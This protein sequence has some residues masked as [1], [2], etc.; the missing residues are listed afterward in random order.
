MKVREYLIDC[1]VSDPGSF[2]QIAHGVRDR[3]DISVFQ[4]KKGGVIALGDLDP[5][6]APSYSDRDT[7]DYWADELRSSSSLD[8][9]QDDLIRLARFSSYIQGRRW[10]DR[11]GPGNLNSRNFPV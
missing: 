3:N 1:G 10:L 4:C 7:L 2:H 8:P 6:Q 11:G 5:V 9:R